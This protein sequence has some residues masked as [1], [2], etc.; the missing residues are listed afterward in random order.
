M[1]T[2]SKRYP[3]DPYYALALATL[4]QALSDALDGHGIEP[5]SYLFSLPG[6][7]ALSR[8]WDGASERDT[9]AMA[10]RTARRIMKLRMAGENHD[11]RK[12]ISYRRT[13]CL[14]EK[15]NNCS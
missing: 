1:E 2:W 9:Y 10:A 7:A 12:L 4:N 11:V 8:M 6:Q 5:L 13:D 15:F 3:A 14:R